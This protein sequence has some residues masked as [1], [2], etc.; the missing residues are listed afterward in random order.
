[1]ELFRRF[2]AYAIAILSIVAVAT[3]TI[4]VYL[5]WIEGSKLFAIVLS[6]MLIGGIMGLL[7]D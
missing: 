3:A 7:K 4:F 2:I 1:M 5:L 6:L